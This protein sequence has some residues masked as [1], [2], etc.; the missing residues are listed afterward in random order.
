MR[1]SRSLT[2]ISGEAAADEAASPRPSM[3]VVPTV[4]K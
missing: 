2:T 1:A 3:M 4:V